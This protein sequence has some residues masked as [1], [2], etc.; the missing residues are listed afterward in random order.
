MDR[1]ETQPGTK[2]A[3]A[4]SAAERKLIDNMSVLNEGVVAAVRQTSKKAVQLS[5]S[6][7]DDLADSLS[8]RANH[9]VDKELQRKL[10]TLVRKIDRLTGGHLRSL[11]ETKV[12]GVQPAGSLKPNRKKPTLTVKRIPTQRETI[13][14]VPL[15]R[16][17]TSGSKATDFDRSTSPTRKLSTSHVV[18]TPRRLSVK[19]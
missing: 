5:P 17:S 16:A 12:P 19:K 3:L 7:L 18:R 1:H 15:V 9:T 4:I 10:D 8:A 13:A 11:L 14:S 2:L 6:Q